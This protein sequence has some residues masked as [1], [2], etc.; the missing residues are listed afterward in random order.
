MSTDWHIRCLD[1]K[2]T[3][4]FDEANHQRSLM[5]ALCRNAAAIAGLSDLMADAEV[6]VRFAAGYTG[7]YGEIDVGWF[8]THLG[9]RLVPIDEYGNL[10]DCC[11]KRVRCTT[12]NGDDRTCYL[13]VGHDG[14]CDPTARVRP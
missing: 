14:D 11:N 10:A 8:K 6:E 3:H 4:R 5:A 9:H 13:P 2:V 7:C 12:C 1:C